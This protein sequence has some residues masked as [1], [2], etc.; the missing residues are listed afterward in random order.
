MEQIKKCLDILDQIQYYAYS[1]RLDTGLYNI[2]NDEINIVKDLVR[3]LTFKNEK[4]V[5]DKIKNE[6]LQF[7]IKYYSNILEQLIFICDLK[8]II[9]KIGS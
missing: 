5:L 7:L 4:V 9:D 6:R 8:I 3:K 2:S 1:L